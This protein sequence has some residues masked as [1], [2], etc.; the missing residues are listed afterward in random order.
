MCK[1]EAKTEGSHVSSMTILNVGTISKILN[2]K[3]VNVD[4]RKTFK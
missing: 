1:M 3:M 2:I 4:Y